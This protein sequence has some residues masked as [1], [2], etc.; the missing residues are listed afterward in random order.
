MGKTKN[1]RTKRKPPSVPK[2]FWWAE[3]PCDFCGDSNGCT[4]CKAAKRA[5]AYNRTKNRAQTKRIIEE[6]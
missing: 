1:A 3:E 5:G 6:G 4:A 2:W